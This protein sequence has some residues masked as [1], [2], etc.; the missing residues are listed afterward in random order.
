[1][2]SESRLLV[3]LWE[4]IVD[5][6]SKGSRNDVLISIM[7]QFEDYG[8]DIIDFSDAVDEDPYIAAVYKLLVDEPLYDED[9]DE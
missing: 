6:I 7:R 1:M 3:N 8:F 4:L 2:N 5:Q 9:E